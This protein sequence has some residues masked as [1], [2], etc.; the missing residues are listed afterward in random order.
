MTAVLA[1]TCFTGCTQFPIAPSDEKVA[2]HIE[3]YRLP[4]TPKEGMALAYVIRPSRVVGLVRF[5]VYVD[6]KTESSRVG[7][8]RSNQYIYFDLEPG[9][10]TIYSRASN[11][12]EITLDVNAGDTIFIEQEHHAFVTNK[13]IQLSDDT[14]KYRVKRA[15]PGKVYGNA[16]ETSSKT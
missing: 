13:L 7:H 3:G 1:V 6:G 16:T 15:K 11:W 4:H 12:S 8:N 10:H 5:D 2:A 14:G 9:D